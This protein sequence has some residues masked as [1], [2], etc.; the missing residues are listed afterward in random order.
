MDIVDLFENVFWNTA[1]SMV[2]LLMPIISITLII[3]IVH[4]F[5]IKGSD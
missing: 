2:N 3:K 5:I 1:T 4:Y